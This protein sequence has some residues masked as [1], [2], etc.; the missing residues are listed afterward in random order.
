MVLRGLAFASVVA[1]A[2]TPLLW[3][4][5][6]RNQ[7]STDGSNMRSSRRLQQLAQGPS[8]WYA[9]GP[10]FASGPATYNHC[11]W[12]ED[13]GVKYWLNLVKQHVLVFVSTLATISCVHLC[14]QEYKFC[15]YGTCAYVPGYCED[16]NHCDV[17][18]TGLPR[19]FETRCFSFPLHEI[20][21]L[22]TS[23]R[24]NLCQTQLRH[25]HTDVLTL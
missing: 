16:D 17:S 21:E 11:R 9:Q 2:L 23:G 14:R 3:Q 6:A 24:R 15:K 8:S 20:T 7:I 5:E 25:R 18:L 13:C 4:C 12:S 1:L 22:V 10:G 19:S